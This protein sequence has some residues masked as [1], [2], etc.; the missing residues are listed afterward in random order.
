[1]AFFMQV[2]EMYTILYVHTVLET[3][4][5]TKKIISVCQVGG[6]IINC[7]QQCMGAHVS[8]FRVIRLGDL[9]QI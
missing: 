2:F 4:I 5:Y 6:I 8:G 7:M 3:N 1:M 9:V